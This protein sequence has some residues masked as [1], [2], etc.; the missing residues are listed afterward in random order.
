M[1]KVLCSYKVTNICYNEIYLHTFE[2]LD[3]KTSEYFSDVPITAKAKSPKIELFSW[4]NTAQLH[5]RGETVPSIITRPNEKACK[6]KNIIKKGS[7]NV[8]IRNEFGFF[9]AKTATVCATKF[10]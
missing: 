5:P 3:Q 6:K 4:Q 1:Q 9:S 10:S 7:K 2:M 8:N